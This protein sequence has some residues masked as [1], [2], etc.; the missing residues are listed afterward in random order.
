MS[1][2]EGGDDAEEKRQAALLLVLTG[3]AVCGEGGENWGWSDLNFESSED[4][5]GEAR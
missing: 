2:G 4:E 1:P 5:E 3:K